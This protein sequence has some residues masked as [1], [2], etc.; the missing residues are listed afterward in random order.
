M[1]T[2]CALA[3]GVP[4][5]YYRRIREAEQEHWWFRGM[6][7]LSRTLLGSRLAA[8]GRVLDAGC[9]TGGY[10]RWL[11]DTG[12]FSSAAGVDVA[13]AA[14]DL[15]HE[16]VPEAE[17]RVAPLA[18]L[19]FGDGSFDLVVTNDVL[20]HVDEAELDRSL[21]ELHRVLRRDGTLL[22]RTNGSRRLRRERS[23]WRAY[24]RA[25]LRRQLESAGFAV[26]RLTHAN[27]MASLWGASRGRVPHAPTED[28]HGIPSLGEPAWQAAVGGALLRLEARWLSLGGTSLPF[29]HTL[30]ALARRR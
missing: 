19:P 4:A 5:D 7:E 16:R 12:A 14:V 18:E 13:A 15:A 11:L 22:V 24:D 9:G 26:E 28:R 30:F 2:P 8:G 3:P 10:L 29:G 17:L 27:C 21:A 25:T 23:D 20:Q 1:T 6:R